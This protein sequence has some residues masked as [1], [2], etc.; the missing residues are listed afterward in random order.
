MVKPV[1]ATTFGVRYG[2]TSRDTRRIATRDNEALGCVMGKSGRPKADGADAR[3]GSSVRARRLLIGMTQGA[4]GDALGVSFQQVQK[5][6]KGANRISASRLRQIAV[7]LDM[8]ITH[9]YGAACDEPGVAES[10]TDSEE[11]RLLT[12]FRSIR[13][14][15]SRR[16]LVSLARALAALA[17]VSARKS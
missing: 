8:P 15:A 5:Y 1:V 14:E 12:A 7:A 13:D 17:E 4:L 2:S 16:H 10:A 6:E 9:F 11:R 3:L